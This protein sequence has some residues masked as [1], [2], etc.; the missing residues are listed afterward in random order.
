MAANS[1]GARSLQGQYSPR[2]S[3]SRS[4]SWSYTSGD[5]QIT[6]SSH[7]GPITSVIREYV[8][9]FGSSSPRYSVGDH[10]RQISES[11]YV[12]LSQADV[13]ENDSR[14]QTN[15]FSRHHGSENGN[16]SHGNQSEFETNNGNESL[17]TT[18]QGSANGR[19]NGDRMEFQGAIKWIESSVPFLLL[20]LSRIMWDH[21]LG[22]LVGIGLTGTFL[23]A[24]NTIKRQVALKVMYNITQYS[25][26]ALHCIICTCLHKQ[27]FKIKHTMH[28]LLY[29]HSNF[30]VGKIN[31][32][33]VSCQASFWWAL[34]RAS[35]VSLSVTAGFE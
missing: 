35:N 4:A 28:I 24:N 17:P 34:F 33:L 1:S 15:V 20:L 11:V 27:D 16:G 18:N 2:S 14:G 22:I 32:L 31:K 8:P 26:T 29:I 6:L 25:V 9:G 30:K 10:Q 7:L 13:V 12:D 19:P 5:G 21:R 23:H 3:H